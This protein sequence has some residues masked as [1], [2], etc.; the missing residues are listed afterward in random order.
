MRST[1]NRPRRGGPTGLVPALAVAGGRRHNGAAQP[2]VGQ[3]SLWRETQAVSAPGEVAEGLRVA[4][5]PNGRALAVWASPSSGGSMLRAA[6]RD[7]AGRWSDPVNLGPGV[8]IGA[9]SLAI[10]SNGD[11]AVAWFTRPG[12]LVVALHPGRAG[13][14]RAPEQITAEQGSS[15][16]GIGDSGATVLL[17]APEFA[18]VLAFER[19]AGAAGF[20]S[21]T[22]LTAPGELVFAPSLSMRPDGAAVAWWLSGFA[23]RPPGGPFGPAQPLPEPHVASSVSTTLALGPTGEVL[24]LR[25]GA[26]NG[27]ETAAAPAGSPLPA[28]DRQVE[29]L[30]GAQTVFEPDGDA[31]VVTTGLDEPSRGRTNVPIALLGERSVDGAWSPFRRV[32]PPGLR[33]S[34][35]SIGAN[36]SGAAVVSWTLRRPRQDDVAQAILREGPA[37]ASPRPRRSRPRSGPT[38]ARASRTTATSG[39]SRSATA[40]CGSPSGCATLRRRRRCRPPSFASTSASPRP[41]CGLRTRS[42]SAFVK[43]SAVRT[44]APEPFVPLPFAQRFRSRGRKAAPSC[45]RPPADR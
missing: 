25:T 10:N 2:A 1:R 6:I 29:G 16:I 23:V 4:M 8:G 21:P 18:R 17:A 22:A 9:K 27:L 42:L 44:S 19:P 3:E 41:P 28:R 45:R 34:G 43:G 7:P 40:W 11:A 12:G 26:G 33:S 36:S 32:S 35:P 5:A 39:R 30:F 15:A 14:W 38:P 24:A 37:G 20:G 31:V 13:A